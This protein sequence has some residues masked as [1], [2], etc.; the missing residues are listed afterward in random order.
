MDPVNQGNNPQNP[1]EEP[2]DAIEKMRQ[3]GIDPNAIVNLMVPVIE[4]VVVKTVEGL[5]LT[6]TM[7]TAINARADQ[8]A[9]QVIAQLN[10]RAD[11]AEKAAREQAPQMAQ[12]R[13]AAGT[14]AL[15][16]DNP[17]MQ[18]IFGKLL[19]VGG[20]PASDGGLDQMAKLASSW[21]NVMKAI[22]QPVVEMQATMRQNLLSEMSTYSKTGGTM[23]WE[24]DSGHGTV[25][26]ERRVANLN[27]EELKIIAQEVANRIRLT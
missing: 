20:S 2:A 6:K 11:E 13:P 4:Q 1:T 26:P 16:P 24:K 19:G 7:E 27:Q 21:G 3:A 9:N 22:M 25:Q 8:I 15:S 17:M 14:G 18:A 5:N 12:V 23:P 10:A